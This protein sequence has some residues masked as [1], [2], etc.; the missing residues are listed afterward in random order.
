MPVIDEFDD[1]KIDDFG[2]IVNAL[3]KLVEFEFCADIFMED[4][5]LSFLNDSKMLEKVRL[6][7]I[8]LPLFAT[9]FR[10]KIKNEWNIDVDIIDC[11]CIEPEAHFVIELE[12]KH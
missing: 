1:L 6:L 12:R 2:K 4:E 3:P 5:L 8:N 9:R 7:F 11:I 10:T